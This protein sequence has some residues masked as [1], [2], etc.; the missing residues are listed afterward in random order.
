MLKYTVSG[1]DMNGDG[2]GQDNSGNN[3]DKDDSSKVM[4]EEYH[5]DGADGDRVT[6]LSNDND[7]KDNRHDDKS[8]GRGKDDKE[9]ATVNLNSKVT[10]GQN[11]WEQNKMG[12]EQ[13]RKLAE[14]LADVSPYKEQRRTKKQ[15]YTQNQ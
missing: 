8:Y 4:A 9:G 6:A 2:V 7:N 15:K 11:R 5:T 14:M 1:V 13:Q 3:G 10:K 12:A